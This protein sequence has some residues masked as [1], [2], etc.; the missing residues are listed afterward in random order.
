[1][2]RFFSFLDVKYIHSQFFTEGLCKAGCGADGGAAISD[3]GK[4]NRFAEFC[5]APNRS[6]FNGGL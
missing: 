1:M 3:D 2:G 4:S 5:G 6:L